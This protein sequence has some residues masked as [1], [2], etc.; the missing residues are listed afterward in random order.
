MATVLA[1]DP[2][3]HAGWAIYEQGRLAGCGL[4]RN[5]AYPYPVVPPGT[6]VIVER[7]QVYPRSVSKADPNDMIELAIKAGEFQGYYRLYG[8]LIPALRIHPRMWKGQVPKDVH[9]ASVLAGLWPFENK[10]YATASAGMAK[11]LHNNVI[12]AIGLGQWWAIRIKDR[13]AA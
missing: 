2:G 11:G 3:E 1:I 10:V 13:Q 12:D 9:N 4:I 7:P 6:H 5:M 8:C